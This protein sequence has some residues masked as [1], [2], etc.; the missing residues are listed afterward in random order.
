MELTYSQIYKILKKKIKREWGKRCHDFSM[1]CCVC[2]VYL[3][4]DTMK[5]YCVDIDLDN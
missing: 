4:L 2:R 3:M 5:D 1:D